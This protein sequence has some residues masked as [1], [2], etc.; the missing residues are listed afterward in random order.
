MEE[1]KISGYRQGTEARDRAACCSGI[2][3]GKGI[4]VSLALDSGKNQN[5]CSIVSKSLN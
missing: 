2:R 4:V 1:A 3:G 5:G